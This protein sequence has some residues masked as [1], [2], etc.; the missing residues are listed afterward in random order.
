MPQVLDLVEQGFRNELDPQGWKMLHQLRRIYQPSRLAASVFRSDIGTSGFVWTEDEAIVGNLSL[1][2]ALPRARRGRLIGNVVVHPDYRGRGIGRA[3]MEAAVDAASRQHA[4][5]IG[6]EVRADNEIACRLYSHLGFRPVGI[7]EH[8]IRPGGLP[9]PAVRR[10]AYSW[11]RSKATDSRQWQ[12]LASVIHSRDQQLVLEIRA[13]LYEF[14]GFGRLLNL[15]LS[16]QREK[17]WLHYN[18]SGDPR[19]A[20]HVEVD[21]RFRFHTWDVLIHPDA[22]VDDAHET[23]QQCLWTT[24]KYPTWPVITIVADQPALM[25]ECYEMGFQRHRTLQQ[26]LLEL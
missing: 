6:L 8:L 16:R 3:L 25:D 22:Q 18:G 12:R 14:G 1:R 19:L 23:L 2:H 11:Q 4:R 26:M 7:A 13:S 17:A 10:P 20:A 5:W 9:W 15:L 24:R 21:Q